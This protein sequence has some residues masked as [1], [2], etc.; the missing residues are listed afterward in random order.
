MRAIKRVDDG[1]KIRI[2]KK[3]LFMFITLTLV[4]ILPELFIRILNLPVNDKVFQLKLSEKNPYILPDLQTIWKNKPNSFFNYFGEPV[5]IDRNGFRSISASSSN[6]TASHTIYCIGGSTT[7]GFGVS[8]ENTFSYILESKLNRSFGNNHFKVVNAGVV[9]F[10]STQGLKLL[11]TKILRFKPDMVVFSFTWNDQLLRTVPIS[12][13]YKKIQSPSFRTKTLFMHSKLFCLLSELLMKYMKPFPQSDFLV[14]AVSLSEYKNNLETLLSLCKSN[15]LDLLLLSEFTS[16]ENIHIND[17]YKIAMETFADVNNIWFT[18][19][20]K[21]ITDSYEINDQ[22]NISTPMLEDKSFPINP[23]KTFKK[24]MNIKLI[25]R[26][27]PEKFLRAYLL[28]ACHYTNLGHERIASELFDLITRIYDARQSVSF[29][30]P[31]N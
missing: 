13:F 26:T 17:D 28:D 5:W 2:S 11:E 30:D 7:F 19:A 15:H 3:I 29:S 31:T 27:D 20:Q 6:E 25:N 8:Q 4:L 10:T 12:E 16:N 18:D 14:P 9:G 1:S 22:E 23:R 24:K 21:T